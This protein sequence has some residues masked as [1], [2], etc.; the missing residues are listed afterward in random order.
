M[1][2]IN[3][4]NKRIGL[5]WTC[6]RNRESIQ[7]QQ[8]ASEIMNKTEIEKIKEIERWNLSNGYIDGKILQKKHAYRSWK[9]SDADFQIYALHSNDK[10]VSTL[11]IDFNEKSFSNQI[12]NM[13][14]MNPHKAYGIK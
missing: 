10:L 7:Q 1:E 13:E 8:N 2:I 6:W 3:E 5:R 4:N 9:E 12:Q 14:E 11:T